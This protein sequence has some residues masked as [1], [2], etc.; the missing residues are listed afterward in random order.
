MHAPG[1]NSPARLLVRFVLFA[2]IGLLIEVFFTAIAGG[3]G[4]NINLR[5][6]KHLWMVIDYGLLGVVL[7]PIARFLMRRNIPLAGR[8]IVYMLGIF[9]I[10]YISGLAFVYAGLEIWDYSHLPLNLH[11]QI[12]LLYAPF[13]YALGFVAE[14]LHG[15]V[16]A[17]AIVF[18]RGMDASGLLA[19]ERAAD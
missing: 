6:Q 16:D 10:E 18:L 1:I 12:T 3:I 2:L 5:G 15:R 19:D 8:A 7:V 4:G 17:C 13:W 14:W 9:I 11:G